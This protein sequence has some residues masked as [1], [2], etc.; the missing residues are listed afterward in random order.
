MFGKIIVCN[1]EVNSKQELCGQNPD[2]SN[3]KAVGT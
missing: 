3:I 1:S 2:F